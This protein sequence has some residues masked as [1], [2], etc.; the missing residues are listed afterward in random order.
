MNACSQG[1]VFKALR[2]FDLGSKMYLVSVVL[3]LSLGTLV[4][5]SSGGGWCYTGCEQSPQHWSDIPGS[6]CGGK[7][8]S[9]IDIVTSEVVAHADLH[10]FTFVNFSYQHA[11]EH[12]ENNGHTVKLTLED[13]AVEVSGG[14]LNGSYS[15]LQFHFHWGDTEFHPGSEHTVDGHRYPMEM[16]IV[17]IKKGLTVEQAKVHPEGIAALG[18]FINATEHGNKSEPW[19]MLTSYVTKNDTEVKL[20]HT[21]SIDDLI[22]EVDRTKFY[23]YHGSLTTPNCS[24]VVVWTVFYEP[25]EIHKDLIRMFPVKAGFTNIHRPTQALNGRHVY[26]SPATPLPPLPPSPSWCY[27]SHCYYEPSKW[28]LLPGSSCGG[29]RQSPVNIE[30]EKAVEKSSLG[31][32]EFTN[33]DN[34]HAIKY[35]TNTGHAVKCVMA[36]DSVEVSGGGL[37]HDYTTLQFHFH[38]GSHDTKGSEHTMDSKRYP[39]EMHIVNKRK[40]LTLE[41]AIATPN[42]L[43]VLGFLIESKDSSKSGGGSSGHEDT[44]SSSSSDMEAW[45]KL[46]SY[47]SAIQNISSQAEVTAEISIDD[48]LGSVN[49]DEYYRYNGS[50]TTPSCNEAVVWTVFTNAVKVDQ[51]LMMKFPTYAGYHDVFRP[52]QPLHG[53][54]IYRSASGA[55]ARTGHAVL[56]LLLASLST[57]FM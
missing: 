26:A 11:I 32:F 1:D 41:E 8:Q 6:F 50:L 30:T 18:F 56:L 7:S 38:W 44:T 34:K 5:G 46:T 19:R 27:D 43:A 10:N 36:D 54:I 31:E 51:D 42:G 24:E 37:G 53:R 57:L 15:A 48:L 55:A 21:F 40:D 22:G 45:K 4:Q 49:R 28:H 29:Q 2:I 20:N 13:G 33:F 39:M 47:L 14:G 25:I 16:H 23:R 3:F 9:P 12:L 35:I 17:T 52:I